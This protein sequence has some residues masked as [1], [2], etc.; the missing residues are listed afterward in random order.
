MRRKLGLFG[1]AVF[2]IAMAFPLG[3]YFGEESCVNNRP[4]VFVDEEE[5]KLPSG[6]AIAIKNT[7]SPNNPSFLLIVTSSCFI[8]LFNL[9]TPALSAP[10]PIP[11]PEEMCTEIRQ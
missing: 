1:L 2:F 10:A 6:N 4:L 3:W 7:A 11:C 9:Y 5:P 8:Y